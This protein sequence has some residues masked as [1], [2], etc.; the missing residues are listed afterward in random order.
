MELPVIK[1]VL[2]PQFRLRFP[3][4]ARIL[5]KNFS[6]Y[7]KICFIIFDGVPHKIRKPSQGSRFK[8]KLMESTNRFVFV[9]LHHLQNKDGG[10]YQRAR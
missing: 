3:Y 5:V 9:S 4:Y 2:K 7:L 1:L 8:N 10:N 6:T